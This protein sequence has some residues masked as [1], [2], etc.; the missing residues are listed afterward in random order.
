MKPGVYF[1]LYLAV[2]LEVLIFILDRDEA[3]DALRRDIEEFAQ[4]YLKPMPDELAPLI[5]LTPVTVQNGMVRTDSSFEQ[6]LRIIGLRG[7][8][9]GVSPDTSRVDFCQPEE[10]GQLSLGSLIKLDS[11]G[12]FDLTAGPAPTWNFLR[13][14]KTPD[15]NDSQ[16]VVVPATV[17]PRGAKFGAYKY[18]LRVHSKRLAFIRS[19]GSV[20]P[21]SARIGGK[22]FSIGLVSRHAGTSDTNEIKRKYNEATY[23]V[24]VA[25]GEKAKPLPPFRIRVTSPGGW[26]M[27]N[28]LVLPIL[29]EGR[30]ASKIDV[31]STNL[32]GQTIYNPP[33]SCW[34]WRGTMPY[35]AEAYSYQVTL[36]ARDDLGLGSESLANTSFQVRVVL[37]Q[38][39]NP[40]GFP[41]MICENESFTV[42]A[43]VDSLDYTGNYRL[44]CSVGG[45]QHPAELS[46]TATF[47][48]AGA[49]EG[50][51]VRIRVLHK[52]RL[53]EYR[54]VN[55]FDGQQIAPM[56]LV[57]TVSK[58][59]AQIVGCAAWPHRVHVGASLLFWA[60]RCCDCDN[61]ASQTAVGGHPRVEIREGNQ[62]L[63]ALF[64]PTI[65]SLGG[66]QY[67]IRLG[68]P[69]INRNYRVRVIVS[70]ALADGT[71]VM[72]C[73]LEIIPTPTAE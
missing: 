38:L 17:N 35:R 54:I 46:A 68:T 4:D 6:S 34:Y 41:S 8:T 31:S 24:Y 33:D 29:V 28:E 14:E 63:T 58:Q 56:E 52:N 16:I 73:N 36:Q 37:P 26:A 59:P 69:T 19:S 47:P 62:D 66:S 60:F 23:T 71:K 30:D 61:Q 15:K 13:G 45:V 49:A 11:L 22:T 67:E 40:M 7:D 70:F 18:T 12:K 72:S 25:M 20:E 32:Q 27:E 55:Y 5:T 51:Q 65:A 57:R 10:K 3:E 21:D 50:T 1:V 48:L 2:I 44:E 64:Q 39:H 43:L 9:S 53:G 42:N